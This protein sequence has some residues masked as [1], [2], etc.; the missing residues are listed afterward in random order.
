MSV[1]IFQTI[2]SE[3]GLKTITESS[4][5]YSSKKIKTILIEKLNKEINLLKERNKLEYDVKESIQ[6]FWRQ[7]KNGNGKICVKY[8][9]SIWGF[10]EE[11]QQHNPTY[12]DVGEYTVDNVLNGLN[13]ILDYIEK[14]DE[15]DKIFIDIKKQK[16][17][18]NN[19]KS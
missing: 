15:D 3:I 11:T 19:S 13:G 12:F 5:S 14:T 10:G 9:N 18:K 1:S 7:S 6:R 8:K 2:G 16:K 4:R 17:D